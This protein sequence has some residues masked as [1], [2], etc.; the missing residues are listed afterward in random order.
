MAPFCW[1][2]NAGRTQIIDQ[3]A[4][5]ARDANARSTC[6]ASSQACGVNCL[7]RFQQERIAQ[8][9]HLVRI[10][11]NCFIELCLRRFQ[12]AD[13]H[14]DLAFEYLAMTSDNATARTSPRR[15]AASRSSA[16]LA[17]SA[18]RDV[19]GSSKLSKIR[20]TSS[21]RASGGNLR[22]WALK[23]SAVD[24]TGVPIRK[25][26]CTATI[27]LNHWRPAALSCRIRWCYASMH[28]KLRFDDLFGKAQPFVREHTQSNARPLHNDDAAGPWATRSNWAVPAVSPI[29]PFSKAPHGP[30]PVFDR[31][32]LRD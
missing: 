30:P 10:P 23:A 16:S 26:D 12:Q 5:L 29:S 8:A 4:R 28:Q 25:G 18:S 24:V 1:G 6:R 31:T 20:S 17:Q 3:R 13:D 9:R 11:C 14:E 22:A 32:S 15:K 21:R 27:A 19:S 7:Q 2:C